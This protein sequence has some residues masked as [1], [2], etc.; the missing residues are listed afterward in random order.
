MSTKYSYTVTAIDGTKKDIASNVAPTTIIKNVTQESNG[1]YTIQLDFYDADITLTKCIEIFPRVDNKPFVISVPEV[2]Q[3]KAN[4]L[5]QQLY[6]EYS[7]EKKTP[8]VEDAVFILYVT[9]ISKTKDAY[10]FKTK[11]NR[12]FMSLQFIQTQEDVDLAKKVFMYSYLT[13]NDIAIQFKEALQQNQSVNTFGEYMKPYI[14]NLK[15]NST[16]KVSPY[17]SSDEIISLFGNFFND[18]A[19]NI[20]G[21]VFTESSVSSTSLNK[22]NKEDDKNNKNTILVSILLIIIVCIAIYM[23]FLKN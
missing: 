12:Y 23:I 20:N 4:E 10:V 14:E 7:E 21:S 16:I 15:N 5:A 9:F 17:N 8:S 13:K 1:F 22:Q 19:T 3:K 18:S 2:E 6:K 11:D